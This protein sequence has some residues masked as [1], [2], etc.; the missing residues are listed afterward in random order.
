MGLLGVIALYSTA[1]VLPWVAV[2]MLVVASTMTT[3]GLSAALSSPWSVPALTAVAAGLALRLVHV[4]RHR[5]D[6]VSALVHPVGVVVLLA[7]AVRS[8]WWSRSGRIAWAGR[9]YGA[10]QSRVTHSP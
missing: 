1:F 2:G 3:G 10:R 7:I 6:V 5:T 4:V 8:W 9:Q